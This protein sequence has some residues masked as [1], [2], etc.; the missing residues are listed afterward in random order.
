MASP[1]K[2]N[3]SLAF[4][5]KKMAVLHADRFL[6]FLTNAMMRFATDSPALETTAVSRSATTA[7]QKELP[8]QIH[9]IDRTLIGKNILLL[10]P[11]QYPILTGSGVL[12][13]VACPFSS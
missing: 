1:A 13:Y 7:V 11:A 4:H 3:F 10:R 6:A 9:R 12:C 2:T 5:V 8:L